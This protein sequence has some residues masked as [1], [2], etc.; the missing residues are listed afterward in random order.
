MTVERG[1]AFKVPRTVPSS[2]LGGGDIK[3]PGLPIQPPLPRVLRTLS[4]RGWSAAPPLG[5]REKE[6]STPDTPAVLPALLLPDRVYRELLLWRAL[7]V[8]FT[9]P[10]N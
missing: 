6:G 3:R 2:V 7:R 1:N 9:G 4:P 10:V 5:Y 8:H